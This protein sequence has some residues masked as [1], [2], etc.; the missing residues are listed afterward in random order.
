MIALD[1]LTITEI[2]NVLTVPSVKH[3]DM[4]MTDRPWY[5]LSFCREGEIVYRHRG[6]EFVSDTG[7][8]V[9]LPKGATY[10]LHRTKTG[11]FPLINFQCNGLQLDTV[12][13]LP[14]S[15]TDRYL[16]D[17]HRLQNAFLIKRNRIKAIG[18]LYEIFDKLIAEQQPKSG[19]LKPAIDMV[20]KHYRDVTLSNTTL[21][22]R[23]GIS[24]VYLRKLFREQLGT[25]PKQ[26]VLDIRLQ[27]AKRLLID[28][29]LT[30]G[31]IA[32]MCGFSNPYHFSRTFREQ[33]G[34]SPT[35]YRQ[36]YR[37]YEM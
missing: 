18:I 29:E 10:S 6:K 22:Q 19:I 7:G 30:I 20:D 14:I 24:E 23:C 31:E 36:Q 2:D 12:C 32:E 26:Y 37:C 1:N 9:L 35:V 28:T 17:F 25:T 34:L 21:S 13:I 4:Q 5:G 27:H 3:Q 11:S 15:S 33:V 8:A 16:G